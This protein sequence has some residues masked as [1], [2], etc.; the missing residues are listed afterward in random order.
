MFYRW[1]DGLIGACWGILIGGLGGVGV[2]TLLLTETLFFTGDTV[3]IGA[4]IF[5]VLGFL[6]GEP[7]LDWVKEIWWKFP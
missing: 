3:L 7:F 4:A 2:C 6:Y 1:R 5:G